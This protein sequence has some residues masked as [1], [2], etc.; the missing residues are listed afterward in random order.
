VGT[1]GTVDATARP[2]R[3][4]ALV[5]EPGTVAASPD[6]AAEAPI[7]VRLDHVSAG[8]GGINALHDVSLTVRRGEVCAVLGPNGAGKSTALKV[9]SGQLQATEGA[10]HL[11]GQPIAGIPT[12]RLI[13]G[14]LCV[15]PEGRGI[16][17]NL[18]V[19]ENLKMASFA[20]TSYTDIIDKS[21]EFF[22]RLAERRGQLAGK[23]SGGE[24]QMV[25]M[26]RALSV[27]PAILLVDELSMGLAPR[28]VEELY[29]VLGQIAKQGL[30][31]VV[32]EQF[33]A[34][35]LKVADLMSA[36]YLGGETPASAGGTPVPAGERTLS[37]PRNAAR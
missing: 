2:A 23:L 15:V 14:G 12:E 36:A 10:A 32:V 25:A 17:P 18:T 33:A 1:E 21:F 16:F 5:R 20:G 3:P 9:I 6:G 31:I 26:A 35:V 22:P 27:N 11:N 4:V 24:Q 8:Y 13:R 34:E 19:T 30:T 28:V 7:A 29:A 37:K